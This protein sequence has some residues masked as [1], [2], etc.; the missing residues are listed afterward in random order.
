MNMMGIM[1]KKISV[2]GT[3]AIVLMVSMNQTFT[4]TTILQQKEAYAQIEGNCD[5]AYAQ[6]KRN[7]TQSNSAKTEI[8]QDIDVKCSGTGTITCNVSQESNGGSTILH[9]NTLAT[10]GYK[11]TR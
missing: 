8:T 9:D 4:L 11:A 7:C 1:Q 3:L 5:Q 2:L 6:I 10:N